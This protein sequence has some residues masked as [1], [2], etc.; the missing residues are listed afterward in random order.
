MFASPVART[1]KTPAP[2]AETQR[3]VAEN[4]VQQ[5][6]E[7]FAGSPRLFAGSL[8]WS[9]GGTPLYPRS[10][11]KIAGQAAV[12]LQRKLAVGSVDDPLER[13]A[14]EIADRVT[15]TPEPSKAAVGFNSVAIRR[16]CACEGTGKPC[17]ACKDETEE[18]LQR[19]P[20][21]GMEHE[22]SG[23]SEAPAIVHDALRSSGNPLDPATR[24]FLESS[25]GCDLAGVRVHTDAI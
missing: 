13:E 9:F 25:L 21:V 16:K 19:K 23:S 12:P 18:S 8:A 20:A 10:S 5:K 11:E 3:W 2:S 4:L 14:D 1:E 15:R 6:P 7:S 17:A 24:A 22:E